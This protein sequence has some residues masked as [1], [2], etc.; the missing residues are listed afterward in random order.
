MQTSRL[1]LFA[2]PLPFRFDLAVPLSQEAKHRLFGGAL[3]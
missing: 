1:I 3:L 2:N